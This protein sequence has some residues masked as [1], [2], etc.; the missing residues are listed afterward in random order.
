MLLSMLFET[1]MSIY[2]AKRLWSILM[3]PR[4]YERI[5]ELQWLEIT[6]EWV[7]VE[8]MPV[9]G[10]TAL[11][12]RFSLGHEWPAEWSG[13]V[14]VT[15]LLEL[16]YSAPLPSLLLLSGFGLETV[17]SFSRSRVGGL[18]QQK[19]YSEFRVKARPSPML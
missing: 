4:D 15:T 13:I 6:I 9:S 17:R 10:L 11:Y 16:F 14:V 19:H 12:R 5:I 3:E 18:L 2:N 1:M 7:C 8:L